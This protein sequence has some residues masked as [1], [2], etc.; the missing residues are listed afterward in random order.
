MRRARV[1]GAAYFVATVI[2]V[3]IVALA[4]RAVGAVADTLPERLSDSEFWQL[5]QGMS[6]P[7]GFFRSDNRC[8]TSCS[9]R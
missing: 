6:E 9:I 8:P 1:P 3:A 4:G 2:A 5:S 7:D